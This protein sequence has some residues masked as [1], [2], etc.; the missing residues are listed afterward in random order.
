[1]STAVQGLE[2]DLGCA[3]SIR[4]HARGLTLTA[5]GQQLFDKAQD[6]LREAVSA[7]SSDRTCSRARRGGWP[8]AS[9]S[10][11]RPSTSR[12]SC[13]ACAR[14]PDVTVQVPEAD[15]VTLHH[16]LCRGACDIALT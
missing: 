16:A 11:W 4:R 8:Q 13:P 2:R 3:L 14:H 10:P 6:L 15:G 9:S 7:S 5:S 12:A 1:M